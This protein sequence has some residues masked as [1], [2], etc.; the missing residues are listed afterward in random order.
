MTA[1]LLRLAGKL[2][3]VAFWG[4][5]AYRAWRQSFSRLRTHCE[6]QCRIRAI[7]F[8][9]SPLCPPLKIEQTDAGGLRCELQ[10]VGRVGGDLLDCPLKPYGVLAS[11]LDWF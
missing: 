1:Y 10:T 6:R 4:R 9:W 8:G 5:G 11:D 2:T 7:A 3:I